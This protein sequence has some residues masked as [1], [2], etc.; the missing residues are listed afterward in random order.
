M[1]NY[2]FNV[3]QNNEWN[4]LRAGDIKYVDVD[5]DGRI[6][7]GN[8]TLDDHGDL[9]PIGNAMPQFPFGFNV[10]AT[11]KG[12]DLSIAGA[13][14][15]KQ[16]WYPTGDIYW[17]TYQRPYLSFLRDDLVSNA[18]TPESV[19][20][21]PQIERGYASLGSGRSLYEMND[22]YMENVGYLRIKNLTVGYTLPQEFTQK[23][24]ID[25][26]R[27][28]F[29]GENLFTWSFGN[30]S[31]YIDPEMAGSAINYSN[32]GNA[33]GRADLR[34]YPM[35]KTYSLGINITL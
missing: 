14:V 25:R 29:S 5:G 34:S 3:V 18:W 35:G 12:F 22:Y 28:Y 11:W 24:E 33:V 27:I 16:N 30:L 17:G 4:R 32:P 2:I 7:R 6:D 21:F 26:F 10:S 1:Y 13:G 20:K 23:F 9:Q 8:Y 15:G 31:K 19:G